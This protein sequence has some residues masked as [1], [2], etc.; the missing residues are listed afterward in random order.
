[1][2]ISFG[3]LKWSTQPKQFV[4]RNKP[5]IYLFCSSYSGIYFTVTRVGFNRSA[6]IYLNAALRHPDE[7]IDHNT[8]LDDPKYHGYV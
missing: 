6:I 1:V 7:K 3:D 4:V 2:S 8:V 5:I